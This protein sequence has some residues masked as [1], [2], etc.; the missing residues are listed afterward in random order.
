[1]QERGLYFA[2][3]WD[4]H[5]ETPLSM[6]DPG[7]APQAGSLLWA[8]HGKGTF[9]YTGLAFFRQLPAGV[10]GAYRLFANLLA[11]GH[12]ASA[13]GET[14]SPRRAPSSTTRRRSSPGGRSTLIVLG[15]LAVEVA[16]RRGADPGCLVSA[17]D[18]LVLFG[19]LARHRRLRDLEDARPVEHAATIVHGGYRDRWLTIGLGVMATQASAITFLSMP[20]QA[21][22]DGM[23]FLQFYFG[24][25]LAMVI[26]SVAF[27]PRFYRLRVSDR[28]R[29]PRRPLRSED[30]A[31]GG[32]SV[33]AAAGA[34]RPGITIYAPAIVL[35]TVLGWPLQPH[36][37]GRSAALVILYTVA[38][39]TRAVSQTQK[40]QMVVM[41]GGM[42]V[43]FV[44][45]VH[46]L[47]RRPVVRP[48]GV[49]GR[50]A[51]QD[52]RR[53]LLA[54]ARQPLHLLVG[55]HRRLLPGLP[56]SGPTSRRCSAIC[57]GGR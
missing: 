12:A 29:I 27:V 30:A 56:T 23:R 31:A 2:D 21:Y 35:S 1:M 17:L 37:R 4:D 51:G 11:G 53:R 5:Y 46:A 41:L 42:V 48:R 22:E 54:A 32:V 7:E 34:R 33:P 47:P 26:L 24:L 18:W 15:A 10:P 40:H 8:R 14:A 16:A 52:E 13:D 9:V 28:V 38:G 20:G 19:T 50:D 57:R 25:P 43:A 44:V 55:P 36:L 49:A 39:G 45:I 3:K 6:H